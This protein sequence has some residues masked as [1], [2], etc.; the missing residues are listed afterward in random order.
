LFTGSCAPVI[1]QDGRR[2]IRAADA[3]ADFPI[4]FMETA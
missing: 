2:W 1:E 4:A 3:F